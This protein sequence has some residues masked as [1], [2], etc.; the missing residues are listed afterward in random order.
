M[1]TNFAKKCTCW[2]NEINQQ[3]LG[4]C[5]IRKLWWYW[6]YLFGKD[7][8]S[9][10]SSS[11]MVAVWAAGDL[12][13][14]NVTLLS[15]FHMV[16]SNLPE[17]FRN[18]QWRKVGLHTGSFLV[19]WSSHNVTLFSI[20][21]IVC[22]LQMLLFVKL[23]LQKQKREKATNELWR[24]IEISWHH[25]IIKYLYDEKEVHLHLCKYKISM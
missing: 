9:R 25:C 23:P 1:E 8:R 17:I 4:W 10:L 22:F 19:I 6:N 12:V 3:R 15:H 7:Y 16:E 13:S 21:P 2:K 14:H 11:I 18:T 24:A 20:A 5:E